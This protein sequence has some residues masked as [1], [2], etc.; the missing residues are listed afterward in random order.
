MFDDSLNARMMSRFTSLYSEISKYIV[1]FHAAEYAQVNIKLLGKAIVDYT[2][3]IERLKDFEGIERVN[4]AKIYAYQTYWLMRRKPIQ[5]TN[6]ADVP[7]VGNYLNE[8]VFAVLL[9]AW[10]CRE[11]GMDI[12]MNNPYRQR[13]IKLLSYNFKY[14]EFNQRSLEVMVEAFLLGCKK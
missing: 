13:F 8:Y 10:M 11:A 1:S 7:E 14:R 4:E 12:H 9:T 5:I 3:D 6:S 2:E